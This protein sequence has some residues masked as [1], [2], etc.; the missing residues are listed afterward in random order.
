M[1]EGQQVLTRIDA[2]FFF[3]GSQPADI[4]TVLLIVPWRQVRFLGLVVGISQPDADAHLWSGRNQERIAALFVAFEHIGPGLSGG[5]FHLSGVRIDG[6]NLLGWSNCKLSEVAFEPLFY[7]YGQQG[8][9]VLEFQCDIFFIGHL[10]SA[11]QK[12]F[13]ETVG[14]IKT[15]LIFRK[16]GVIG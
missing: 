9:Q 15:V 2:R 3:G 11:V 7:L 5:K 16:N 8:E 14:F 10:L 4:L 12:I 13:Q 6:G 1:G